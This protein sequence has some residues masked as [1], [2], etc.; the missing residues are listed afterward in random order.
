MS[1]ARHGPASFTRFNGI[2]NHTRSSPFV[3]QAVLQPTL[4]LSSQP[5]QKRWVATSIGKSLPHVSGLELN[6][7]NAM[8]DS[9]AGYSF[10]WINRPTTSFPSTSHPLRA[11]SRLH[12]G[13][14]LPCSCA[15]IRHCHLT[16]ES[17]YRCRI[18]YCFQ[19]SGCKNRRDRCISDKSSAFSQITCDTRVHGIEAAHAHAAGSAQ[20]QSYIWNAH[21]PK[22]NTGASLGFCQ[23]RR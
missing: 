18:T 5:W 13:R 19:K 21:R 15:C 14:I 1:L 22:Q 11:F 10:S 2:C 7:A 4:R 17:S 23:R 6:F 12:H 3:N 20:T 9:M 16:H 8:T